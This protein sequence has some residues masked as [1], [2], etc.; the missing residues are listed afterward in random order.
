MACSFPDAG[1]SVPQAHYE[2]PQQL[3]GRIEIIELGQLATPEGFHR[4]ER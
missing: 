1:Q 3:I 4:I 2:D